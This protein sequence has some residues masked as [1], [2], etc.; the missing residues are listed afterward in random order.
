MTLI[1]KRTQPRLRAAVLL[2]W[3][4][5]LA[6]CLLAFGVL[7]TVALRP[8]VD[9]FDRS[10]T[11]QVHSAAGPTMDAAM[12]ALT[13][14]GSSVL[15]TALVGLVALVL[16]LRRAH[17][18]AALLVTALVGTLALNEA[19]K[20]FFARPRPAL[21]WAEFATGLSFPSGHAMN[22]FV[23]YVVLG[24]LIL[25]WRG[26]RMGVAALTL[27][28]VVAALVGISRVYLGVHWATDVTAGAVAG[29]IYLLVLVPAWEVLR[30]D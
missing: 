5:A 8:G 14:L 29:A 17:A 2:G 15:L 7:A 24:L 6:L 21:D 4:L 13:S 19:L 9:A 23:V 16:L 12:H 18:D 25:R 22:S 26:V 10:V 30:R 3:C 11:T 28:L 20:V 27:A 1:P